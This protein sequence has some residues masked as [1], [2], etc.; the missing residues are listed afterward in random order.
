MAASIVSVRELARTFEQEIGGRPIARRRWAVNLSDN[1]LVSEGGPPGVNALISQCVGGNG[2]GFGAAHP[3]LAALK[4]RKATVTERFEDDPYKV[5]VVAEYGVVSAEELVHPTSRSPQWSF[6]SQPGEIAALSYYAG[7]G[8]N[9]RRPLTNSAFDYFPGLTT[10]ESMVQL[11]IRQ[12]FST[13]TGTTVVNGVF[14]GP[15]LWARSQGFVNDATYAGCPKHT[16]KVS[17]VES[18]FTVSEFGGV[19]V[20]YYETT[21]TL[22][23]RQSSHNLLLPDVGWNFIVPVTGEKRRA[24]VF[25]FKNG[26]WVASA[27]PVGLDG[28]GNQT[29][30]APAIL[31]GG[32]GLRVCPE[33]N[34]ANI[35]GTP[36]S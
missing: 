34:F 2:T 1:A 22:L 16:L 24:M 19:E 20:S 4:F 8:N 35:F 10:E 17:S 36:P 7:N 30:G 25:D 9:D 14:V 28:S 3:D 12:N 31:G 13:L 32:S 11:K 18:Q 29:F 27:N 6:S 26:E 21:A 23:F 33:T 5:E 15:W